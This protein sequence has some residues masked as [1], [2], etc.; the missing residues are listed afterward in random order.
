MTQRATRPQQ[1]G[2]F[3]RPALIHSEFSS[4]VALPGLRNAGGGPAIYFR[5]QRRAAGQ[6]D[7]RAPWFRDAGKGREGAG[8]IRGGNHEFVDVFVQDAPS[9]QQSH[10]G[11]TRS[12]GSVNS[13]NMKTKCKQP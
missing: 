6:S 9:S 12:S 10:K 1:S 7:H 5:L 13:R 2:P 11:A 3:P 8:S 4:G